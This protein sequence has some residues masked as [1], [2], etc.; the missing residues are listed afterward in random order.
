MTRFF[1]RNAFDYV[2]LTHRQGDRL[3]SS[4]EFSA[5]VRFR[6]YA[7]CY[8]MFAFCS[9]FLSLLAARGMRTQAGEEA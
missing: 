6:T 7:G 3:I 2:L 5:Q 9:N 8:V 4:T 1:N